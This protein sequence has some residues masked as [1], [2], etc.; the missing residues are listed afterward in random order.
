MS[1]V[2]DDPLFKKTT[3]TRETLENGEIV[4]WEFVTTLR[5]TRGE[6]LAELLRQES[7]GGVKGRLI[8]VFRNGE[9][10]PLKLPDWFIPGCIFKVTINDFIV[11]LTVKPKLQSRIEGITEI[12]GLSVEF[13]YVIT[14]EFNDA[15]S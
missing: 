9:P 14:G 1:T 3:L 5:Q 12:L 8:K 7:K 4:L 11:V 13:D 10:Q 2:F 15:V 6:Y